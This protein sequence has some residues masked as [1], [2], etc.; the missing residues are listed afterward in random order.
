MKALNRRILFKHGKGRSATM[1]NE[2]NPAPVSVEHQSLHQV[3]T[4]QPSALT[5]LVEVLTSREMSRTGRLRDAVR[6]Y[7]DLRESCRLLSQL[8]GVEMWVPAGIQAQRLCGCE[9]VRPE[10]V[11]R[12][13]ALLHPPDGGCFLLISMA[14][15]ADQGVPLSMTSELLTG[16]LTPWSEISAWAADLPGPA[17]LTEMFNRARDRAQIVGL[18]LATAREGH[19]THRLG[20]GFEGIPPSIPIGIHT[21]FRA[22]SITKVV[23]ALCVLRLAREG[24]INIGAPA[25]RY[26]KQVEIDQ[27][28][29]EEPVTVR[30]L[31]NHTSGLPRNGVVGAHATKREIPGRR[32]RYSNLAYQI[33]ARIVVDVTG[34]GFADWVAR[35]LFDPLEM[36][37]SRI[38]STVDNLTGYDRGFGFVWP[39]HSPVL[40]DGARGLISTCHDLSILGRSVIECREVIEPQPMADTA[41]VARGLGMF[42]RRI[43]NRAVAV[44]DGG[45][46]NSWQSYLCV[47]PASQTVVAC[48][49]NS[50]PVDLYPLVRTAIMCVP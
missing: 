23:T 34:T 7:P 10:C 1:R 46:T 43:D 20:A 22:G 40:D 19:L 36:R 41:G 12:W 9:P 13:R 30:H 26:L 14:T 5:R 3:D 11:R 2:S 32:Y 16:R 35:T 24:S 31:L 18:T 27:L 47:E 45:V 17:P 33:L 37:D 50:H 8:A 6:S 39:A 21:P 42:L 28:P 15:S 25:N 29:G 4:T 44:H 49:A 48:A 38:E